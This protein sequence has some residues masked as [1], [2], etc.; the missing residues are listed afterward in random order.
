VQGVEEYVERCEGRSI[1]DRCARMSGRGAGARRSGGSGWNGRGEVV[2]CAQRV[3]ESQA[4]SRRSIREAVGGAR[5]A[6]G[7]AM[8]LDFLCL[9]CEVL[10]IPS[11]RLQA[12]FID[13][14][15][16]HPAGVLFVPPCK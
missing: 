6:G 7:D 4:C 14:I 13:N 2:P 15:F 8:H 9:V 5:W 12:R 3:R 1:G 10:T 11:T 16:R